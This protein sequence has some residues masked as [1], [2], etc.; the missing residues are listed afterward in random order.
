MSDVTESPN[1]LNRLKDLWG[2]GKASFGAIVTIPSIQ[3]IQIL[4]HTGFDWF[5]PRPILRPGA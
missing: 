3:V 4:A 1:R 2:A 5:I